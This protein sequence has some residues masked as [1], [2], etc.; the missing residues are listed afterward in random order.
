MNPFRHLFHTLFPRRPKTLHL[1]AIL[2]PYDS[3]WR[4]TVRYS[5]LTYHMIRANKQWAYDALSEHLST[6]YGRPVEL[7]TGDME[8]QP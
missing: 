6:L 5:G 2:T 4:C 1:H 3:R 7:I 8:V